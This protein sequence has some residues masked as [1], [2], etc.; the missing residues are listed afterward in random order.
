MRKL[1]KQQI[2]KIRRLKKEGKLLKNLAK[3]FNVSV[4]TIRRHTD[5]GFKNKK[6]EYQREYH[7]KR[8][9]EDK[10]FREKQLK[11]AKEY[12]KRK[13]QEKKEN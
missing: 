8:Y 9:K 7:R 11:R 5:E 2:E 1:T 12:Q 3:Q 6:R 10:E 13:Y 4:N